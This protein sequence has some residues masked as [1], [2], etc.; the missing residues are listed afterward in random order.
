MFAAADVFV[1]ASSIQAERPRDPVLLHGSVAV[2][3][4]AL[5]GQATGPH[6]CQRLQN[7]VR[8]EQLHHF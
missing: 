2:W 4:A 8:E 1:G 5:G 6:L 7:Q 3:S